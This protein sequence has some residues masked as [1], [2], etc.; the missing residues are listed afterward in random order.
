[1]TLGA[2][3]TVRELGVMTTVLVYSGLWVFALVVVWGL[4]DEA[5]IPRSSVP[6]IS[7]V[8]TIVVL[9]LA[10]L[11]SLHPW[12]GLVTAA[13]IGLTSPAAL[14]L[15]ARLAPRPPRRATGQETTGVLLDPVMLDRRFR[16]IVNQFRKFGD[17]LEA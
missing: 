5:D 3:S 8:A 16:E 2:I 9:V 4:A 15:M 14:G 6:R 7:L 1:M 17:G 11:C 10:G 13:L 12:Y